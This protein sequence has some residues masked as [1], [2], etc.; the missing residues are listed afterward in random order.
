MTFEHGDP[1]RPNPRGERRHAVASGSKGP[2]P[3]LIGFIVLAAIV[4]VFIIANDHNTEVSFG[5][6]TWHTT[7]RWSIFIAI[8]L[9]V[10]LDRLLIFGLR[11]RNKRKFETD[12]END[13]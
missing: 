8:L 12:R 2:S 7:V 10:A 1:T 6:F 9:G 4:V 13:E 5:F 11:R 3:K